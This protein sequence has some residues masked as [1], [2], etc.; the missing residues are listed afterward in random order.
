M[1]AVRR[2]QDIQ[3]TLAAPLAGVRYLRRQTDA[4]VFAAPSHP[5]NEWN[6]P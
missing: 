4:G 3:I 1:F 6:L 5:H 2:S